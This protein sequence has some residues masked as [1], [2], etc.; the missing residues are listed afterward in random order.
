MTPDRYCQLSEGRKRL[1]DVELPQVANDISIA[2]A[3]GGLS[4]NAA[5]QSAQ[6]R[7]RIIAARI[8]YL[9]QAL[10]RAEVIDPA[11]LIGNLVEFGAKLRLLRR[12]APR[13]P[14]KPRPQLRYL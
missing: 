14:T 12:H 8:S 3:R 1:R 5:Y 9:K 11:K 10:A 4:E 2:R 6:E 13:L 7:R